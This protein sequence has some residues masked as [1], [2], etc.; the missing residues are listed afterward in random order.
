MSTWSA[1]GSLSAWDS[2]GR[3]AMRL[4]LESPQAARVE[5]TEAGRRAMAARRPL[6]W[7]A[8]THTAGACLT[9]SALARPLADH[10]PGAQW[11]AALAVGVAAAFWAVWGWSALAPLPA[12]VVGLTMYA[13]TSYVAWN[14]LPTL[15]PG[16]ADGVGR[17][18]G[19]AIGAAWVAGQLALLARAVVA[20]TAA[21]RAVDPGVPATGLFPALALH[22]LLL[23][24]VTLPRVLRATT[25]AVTTADVIHVMGLLAVVTVIAAVIGWRTVWPA[26]ADAGGGWL[27][28]G[29]LLG[30]GS[31]SLA[32]LYGD[33][34][35]FAFH[36]PSPPAGNMWV[37]AG[38]GWAGAALATVMFPAV[39]EE[40][41][42]RGL[43][44]PRL[45]RVMSG[46]ETA[47]VSGAMFAVLHLDAGRVPFLLPMG[48]ALAVLRRRSGSL[49]PC[50]LMHL[51]HNAAVLY[52]SA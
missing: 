36:L 5:A 29:V 47:V 15:P 50:V 35:A 22:G 2:G 8:A 28:A 18:L 32:S 6:L 14:T 26:L 19:Q 17:L 49:W 27:V 43:I 51:S 41:A 48:I 25:G 12:A 40:L 46:G 44:V 13:T 11:I 34:A 9:L 7:V 20:G 24:V 4:Y 39:F 52:W 45:A 31:F 37:D 1:N 33:L 30:L 16:T 10:D 21:R 23:G 38:Y 3:L 42:F